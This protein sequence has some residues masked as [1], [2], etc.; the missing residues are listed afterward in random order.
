[1]NTSGTSQTTDNKFRNGVLWFVVVALAA[2]GVVGN[3][4]FQEQSVLFRAVA[5]VI[6]A[7]V[8]LGLWLQTA[9]GTRFRTLYHGSRVE[10][11][12]VVWPTRQETLQ[13]SLVVLLVVAVIS[14]VLWL[15]D[16]LFAWIISLLVGA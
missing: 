11:R 14:L 7:A 16:S 12:K 1:M 8:A 9:M 4:Y 2:A 6:V 10:L 13:S 15:F 3:I 5:L